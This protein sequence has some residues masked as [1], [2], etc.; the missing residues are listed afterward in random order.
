MLKLSV[1]QTHIEGLMKTL[2][3]YTRLCAMK[4]DTKLESEL[5]ELEL[6]AMY[7]DLSAETAMMFPGDIPTSVAEPIRIAMIQTE[8]YLYANKRAS[9]N[10]VVFGL[11][12]LP[13]MVNLTP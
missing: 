8:P 7:F 2:V 13:N 10:E 11:F 6:W 12:K 9:L 4:K 3:I 5:R 1:L